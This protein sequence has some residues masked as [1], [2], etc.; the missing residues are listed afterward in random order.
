M[1]IAAFPLLSGHYADGKNCRNPI[2]MRQNRKRH[3]YPGHD[4][5]SAT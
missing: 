4:E 5:W 1:F 3:A 2:V